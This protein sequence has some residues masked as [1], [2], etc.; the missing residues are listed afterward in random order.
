MPI[1]TDQP[2]YVGRIDRH[3][4]VAQRDRR[5][6][7]VLES[8][9]G[10]RSSGA[11]ALLKITGLHPDA[12]TGVPML[13]GDIYGNGSTADPTETGVTVT[14]PGLAAGV[15]SPSFGTWNDV[16]HCCGVS[17]TRTWTGA[18]ETHADDTVYE[19]IGLLLV[20]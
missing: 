20:I 10:S 7:E 17:T 15:T 8:G 11:V 5:R 19:A 9:G 2:A 12:P 14:I 6:I 4:A 18:T 3:L 16:P 1:A 13:Q